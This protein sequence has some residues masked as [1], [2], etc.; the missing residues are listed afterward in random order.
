VKLI[1][2]CPMSYVKKKD[3]DYIKKNNKMLV[4]DVIR[5]ER[6]ISRAN[7][8]KI[9]EMSPTSIGRIVSEL[10]NIGVVKETDLSSSG[11]GRKAIFLDVD[12]K[13]ILN[14]GVYLNKDFCNLGLID[15]DGNIIAYRSYNINVHEF[16]SDEV[17]NKIGEY[18]NELKTQENVDIS[19]IIGVGI[20]VPGIVDYKKGEVVLSAQL[21]WKNVSVANKIFNI[22]GLKTTI[23]NSLKLHAL[24]ETMYGSAV[25]SSI[26]SFINIG[27]GVGSALVINGQIYRGYSNIAGEVGHITVNPNGMLCECG[28]RGCLQ[29]YMAEGALIKEVSKFKK[30][31]G[32]EDIFIAY[33]NG[34]K[35]AVEILDLAATY[36]GITVNNVLGMYNPD[37][38]ILS[39]DLLDK[40]EEMRKLVDCKLENSCWDPFKGTFKIVY[41]KL[42]NNGVLIGA[43][44]FSLKTYMS[45]D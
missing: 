41:S 34:E 1:G 19:K 10:T 29:T 4:F 16:T 11:V 37:T 23:D 20:G 33:R 22:T 28:K 35:W 21:G 31:D 14:I 40:H 44:T 30:I 2:G 7:I 26:A 6:P 24:A 36:I 32:I 25:G 13:S 42:Q 39:G 27:A 43:A 3:Q 15:F 18:I 45:F 9:T 8:A 12:A 5:N 17:I 38:I